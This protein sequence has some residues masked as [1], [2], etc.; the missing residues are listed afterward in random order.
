M[1]RRVTAQEAA[2]KERVIN[3]GDEDAHDD[4]SADGVDVDS[5]DRDDD[6]RW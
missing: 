6:E 3:L 4:D 5:D 2:M 1:E